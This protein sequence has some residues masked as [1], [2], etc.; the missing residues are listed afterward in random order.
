MNRLLIIGCGD[1]ARRILPQL[2][3]RYRVYALV[4]AG[5][6]G[7]RKQGVTQIL[8]DLDR[9]E[10]LGRLCGLADLV[11]YTVPPAEQRDQ[12]TRLQSLLG[13]LRQGQRRPRAL[14]YISTSG[15]YGDHGGALVSET[16][17]SRAE[18]P[19]GRR[20]AAAEAALRR[21]GRSA[22]CRVVILRAPGIYAEDRLPLER[23]RRGAP[24]LF[25][26]E[27]VYTNHIHA[28]DLGRACLLALNRGAA[29]RTYNVSDDSGLKMG[30]WYD[31]LADCHGLR[32]P[33][34]VTRQEAI[35]HVAPTMLSFMNE[36]RRLD[37]TRL[38]REMGFR[39]KYPTVH[40]ALPAPAG[41]P[42]PRLRKKAVAVRAE[43]QT[44]LFDN[45]PN[46]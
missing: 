12:D 22:D 8:G 42:K 33:P 37:N 29:N 16:T 21:F 38:K 28:D 35:E 34:R 31:L 20:R 5:D 11:L 13:I 43:N 27:D 17:P 9:S 24:V 26:R 41:K 14:V 10:S 40:E 2:T 7:L 23:L 44:D 18:S 45:D 19:R 15:V 4:R 1:V 30:D 3:R 36:S 25:A 39:F 46:E 6:E 32:R